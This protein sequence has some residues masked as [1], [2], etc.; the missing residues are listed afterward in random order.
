[1]K[2]SVILLKSEKPLNNGRFESLEYNSRL[3]LKTMESDNVYLYSIGIFFSK[4]EANEFLAYVRQ[5]GFPDA[6]VI[7]QYQITE[8]LTSVDRV[9]EPKTLPLGTK[10]YTIQ[11][12]AT[13]GEADTKIFDG[14]S[15]V[16]KVEGDDGFIRYIYGEYDTISDTRTDL[17]RLRDNGFPD[18]FVR[19]T[20]DL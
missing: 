5:E 12:L 13:R 18:A 3:F 6:F 1:M 15:G 20:I 4:R 19:E 8:E 17:S 2:Y 14:L 10:R 16:T 9:T 7:N 11:I